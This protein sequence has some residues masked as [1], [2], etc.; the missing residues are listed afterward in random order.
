MNIPGIESAAIKDQLYRS[1][2]HVFD[3]YDQIGVYAYNGPNSEVDKT[4]IC[5][6]FGKNNPECRRATKPSGFGQPFS[7]KS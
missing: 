4:K 6:V 5:E 2:D 3:L 1:Y 7:T